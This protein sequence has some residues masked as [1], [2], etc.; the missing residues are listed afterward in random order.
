MCLRCFFSHHM[1]SWQ[2]CDQGSDGCLVSVASLFEQCQI[3]DDASC[4][5]VQTDWCCGSAL[6]FRISVFLHRA[7]EQGRTVCWVL[8]PFFVDQLVEGPKRLAHSTFRQKRRETPRWQMFDVLL[9]MSH[10]QRSSVHPLRSDTQPYDGSHELL[11]VFFLAHG[12]LRLPYHGP[13]QSQGAA[14]PFRLTGV[15][16]HHSC[17]HRC[18]SI[19]L[20]GLIPS[21]RSEKTGLCA[22]RFLFF[23]HHERKCVP[24]HG[25]KS[26]CG[27][28][29]RQRAEQSVVCEGGR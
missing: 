4:H 8:G 6:G 21:T 27:G 16:L 28:Q 19:T 18:C 10:F 14:V 9:C 26:R 29:R 20:E 23:S 24:K 17:G 3:A 1:R 7:M 5:C 15:A 13:V 25:N 22:F 2:R 12:R 11:A